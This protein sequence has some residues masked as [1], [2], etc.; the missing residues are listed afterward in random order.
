MG[1][2]GGHDSAYGPVMMDPVSLVC[3]IASI[4][5]Q[6]G[7]GRLLPFHSVSNP[8][9]PDRMAGELTTLHVLKWKTYLGAFISS[10]NVI[11]LLR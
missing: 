5:S 9:L 4:D 6:C 8:D 1:G 10:F 2:G 7:L 11:T 3:R